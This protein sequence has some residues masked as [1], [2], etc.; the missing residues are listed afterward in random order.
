MT[1]WA[2]EG[3]LDGLDDDEERAARVDL[4]D[5]LHDAGVSIDELRRAVEEDRLVML[6]AE[7]AFKGG[8]VSYTRED[9]AEKSGLPVDLLER[10]WQ[11]LGLPA[12]P[13][14]VPVFDDRDVEQAKQLKQFI[15]AGLPEAG[16]LGVSRAIG[17]GMSKV[18]ETIREL[19]GSALLHAG[20][21]ERDLGL[22]YAAAARELSPMVGDTLRYV[23][24]LQMR[25]GMRSALVGAAERASG[26][27]PGA[28]DVAVGFADLVGFTKLGEHLPPEEIGGV[29]NELAD[30]A[31]GVAKRPV[32]LVKTIGDA[33]MLVAPTPEP[34]IAAMIELVRRAD[35]ARDGFPQLRAG[36]AFGPALGRG[37]DW[38]GQPVNVASRVTGVARPG[39]VL[40]TADAKDKAEDAFE[41]S[42]AGKRR[43]KNVKGEQ[44]LY[45]ARLLDGDN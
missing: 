35:D 32:R 2:E 7:Q 13:N 5:Q 10:H 24:D 22:R 40:V 38:Y 42:F 11:A 33:A 43:L 39:S 9:L 45:R 4:L 44:P 34:L 23:Y 6:P 18:A 41:W 1:D 14:D 28:E 30:M 21:S 3:L 29:A 37:G 31:A 27:L 16:V 36:V 15:D 19:A 26:Q 12:Q 20:D 17:E 25:E 8:E